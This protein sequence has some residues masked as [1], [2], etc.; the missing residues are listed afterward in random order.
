MVE[1]AENIK[2]IM[3][4]YLRMIG[5]RLK[6]LGNVLHFRNEDD[7][8]YRDIAAGKA[9]IDSIALVNPTRTNGVIISA[10]PAT[11]TYSINLPANAP[12]VGDVLQ[13]ADNLGNTFWSPVLSG[14]GVPEM[15]EMPMVYG[16][17]TY[18]LLFA[19]NA[20]PVEAFIN[21]LQVDFT[22]LSNTITITTYS[23]GDI[24]ASDILRVFY[25]H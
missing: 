10:D 5:G 18:P 19:P 13:L 3:S 16:Q 1:K 22:I 25:Y 23:A 21:G 17:V 6:W 9:E 11:T 8:A 7:T 20:R 12:V 4:S 24:E 14:V 2:R 15:E